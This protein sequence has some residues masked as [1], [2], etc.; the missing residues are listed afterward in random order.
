[1]RVG[2][3]SSAVVDGKYDILFENEPFLRFATFTVR[4]Q[5]GSGLIWMQALQCFEP[6]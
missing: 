6:I 3:L 2:S 1:M 5:L 4:S